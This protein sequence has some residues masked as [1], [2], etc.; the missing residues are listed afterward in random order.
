MKLNLFGKSFSVGGFVQTYCFRE[1]N[2]LFLR[3]SCTR[4]YP[5]HRLTLLKDI[6][7]SNQKQFYNP[8]ANR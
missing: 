7:H 4:P 1:R 2:T 6:K 8:V 5:I 3:M